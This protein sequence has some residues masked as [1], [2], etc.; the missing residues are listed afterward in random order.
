MPRKV[1]VINETFSLARAGEVTELYSI[2]EVRQFPNIH[3][4]ELH[5]CEG[6][7]NSKIVKVIGFIKEAGFTEDDPTFIH[8]YRE[9][10]KF[11]EDDEF[12]RN[13]DEA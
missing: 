9:D 8:V 12:R 3:L 13:E 1:K 6:Y 10:I 2:D 11:I 7:A 5:F 4:A